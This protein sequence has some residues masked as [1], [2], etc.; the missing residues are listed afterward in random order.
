MDGNAAVL[1]VTSLLRPPWKLTI[2]RLGTKGRFVRLG[3]L[4]EA[5]RQGRRL[6]G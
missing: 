1:P 6:P 4:V 5:C 2:L 3:L